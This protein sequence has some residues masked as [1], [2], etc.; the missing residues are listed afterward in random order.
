MAAKPTVSREDL[1]SIAKLQKGVL[2][3]ILAQI[4][5]FGLQFAM[6]ENLK[7]VLYLIFIPVGIL[8]AV[9]VIMLA[10]KI[11][12]PAVGIILGLLSFVPCLGLVV[13][14]IINS[15]ATATLQANGIGVGL[16]GARMS[17]LSKP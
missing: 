6:P 13:L 17:D 8:S 2:L 3:C 10:L 5:L 4:A 11:Y 7:N 9:L 1:T 15:R 14:L 12:S 16:L